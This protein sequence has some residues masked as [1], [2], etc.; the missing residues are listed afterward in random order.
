[1]RLVVV[2]LLVGVTGCHWILPLDEREPDGSVDVARPDLPEPADAE[3]D[4]P[5]PDQNVV[6]WKFGKPE[7]VAELNSPV[8]DDDPSLTADRL[9]IFF[10]SVRGTSS[11]PNKNIWTS[12]R[13][14]VNKPWSTPVE[15]PELKSPTYDDEFAPRVSA[16]GLTLFLARGQSAV[17]LAQILI[18]T[19]PDRKSPWKAPEEIT[20]LNSQENDYPGHP[21]PDIAMLPVVSTRSATGSKDRYDIFL[22]RRGPGGWN[23]PVPIPGLVNTSFADKDPWLSS[24]RKVLYLCS[25][26]PDRDYD[27]WVATRPDAQSPF[28]APS[29]VEGVNVDWSADED[30]WLSPDMME[31]YFSSFRSGNLD[32]YRAVRQPP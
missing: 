12:T 3:P 24:D 26:A 22:A 6:P 27:I 29:R 19:R 9:V 32:I 18:T 21:T 20:A 5:P 7:A 2:S 8:S 23:T 14:D 25:D 30:P 16:D 13:D 1:M 11:A 31:I 28:S 17:S 15:V 4:R 10:T